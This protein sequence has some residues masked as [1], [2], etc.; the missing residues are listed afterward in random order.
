MVF[1]LLVLWNAFTKPKTIFH[2]KLLDPLQ[3]KSILRCR[4]SRCMYPLLPFFIELFSNFVWT[5]VKIK[6]IKQG[7]K[8]FAKKAKEYYMSPIVQHGGHNIYTRNTNYLSMGSPQVFPLRFHHTMEWSTKSKVIWHRNVPQ[9]HLT[10]R[11]NSHSFFHV[12]DLTLQFYQRDVVVSFDRLKNTQSPC[13]LSSQRVF[14]N[15]LT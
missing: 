1:L 13:C 10:S 15:L 8:I 5:M 12:S 11:K 9:L 4:M 7:H 3:G 14:R 6:R 2:L